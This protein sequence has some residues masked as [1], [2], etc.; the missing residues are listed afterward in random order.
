[1]FVLHGMGGSGKSQLALW[2]CQ[3]ARERKFTATLWINASSPSTVMQSYRSILKTIYSSHETVKNG[4]EATLLA[5][6]IGRSDLFKEGLP[7]NIS[8]QNKKDDIEFDS[9]SE[10]NII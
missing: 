3:K 2:C 7:A 5:Q 4:S 10:I 1:M 6:N 9:G 8:D